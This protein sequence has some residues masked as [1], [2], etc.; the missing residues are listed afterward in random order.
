MWQWP[1]DEKGDETGE[2]MHDEWSYDSVV[3]WAIMGVVL[4]TENK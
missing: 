1:Y 2:Q 4:K 3:R